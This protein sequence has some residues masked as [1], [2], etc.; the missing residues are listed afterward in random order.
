MTMDPAQSCWLCHR[1][2]ETQI[3][4]HHP[5]PKAKKGKVKVPVHPMCHTAIHTHFTNSQLARIGDDRSVLLANDALAKF[6]AWVKDKPP[7]FH[8][9]TRTGGKGRR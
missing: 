4:W 8:A 1:P 7:G 9:P 2:F 5:V 6:I 3:E